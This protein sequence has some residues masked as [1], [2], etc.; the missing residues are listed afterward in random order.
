MEIDPE[1]LNEDLS[2]LTKVEPMRRIELITGAE[3][4]RNRSPDE[5]A[6][7]VAESMVP[8]AVIAGVARRHGLSPQQLY[9]WRSTLRA[10]AH[11]QSEP[12]FSPIVVDERSAA[13]GRRG[14]RTMGSEAP[15]DNLAPSIELTIGA[16][17]VIIRGSAD[18]RTLATVLKAL[19]GLA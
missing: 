7:I 3:R 8:G 2:E 4:R 16:A 5:K 19:K 13:V 14:D 18:G 17:R 9:G 12:A 11:K 1:A 15:G 6:A 10:N